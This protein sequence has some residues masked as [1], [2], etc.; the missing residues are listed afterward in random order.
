MQTAPNA[1]TRFTNTAAPDAPSLKYNVH[2]VHTGDR[3]NVLHGFGLT[4]ANDTCRAGLLNTNSILLTITTRI[5]SFSRS[6]R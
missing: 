5:G 4:P 1:G 3:Y 6:G 2:F